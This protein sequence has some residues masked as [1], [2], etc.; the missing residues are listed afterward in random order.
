MYIH[1][2]EISHVVTQSQIVEVIVKTTCLVLFLI[3]FNVSALTV[4]TYI[5]SH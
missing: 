5:I 1:I 3:D 2:G 4:M